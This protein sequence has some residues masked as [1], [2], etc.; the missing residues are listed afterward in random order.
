MMKYLVLITVLATGCSTI[1]LGGHD[2]TK[3]EPNAVANLPAHGFIRTDK[4]QDICG[5]DSTVTGGYYVIPRKPKSGET[6]SEYKNYLAAERIRVRACTRLSLSCSTELNLF[7][8]ADDEECK[9]KSN[10]SSQRSN[11]RIKPESTADGSLSPILDMNI[12]DRHIVC[13][14]AQ[15]EYTSALSWLTAS[16]KAFIKDHKQWI[17]FCQKYRPLEE[18]NVIIKERETNSYLIEPNANRWAVETILT[19]DPTVHESDDIIFSTIEV[20]LKPSC[21]MIEKRH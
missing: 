18:C 11:C 16:S 19:K 1:K 8:R 4:T 2:F 5:K 12:G 10:Y 13:G 14:T 6:E 9:E 15:D 7:C 21:E 20:D 17:K 3:A